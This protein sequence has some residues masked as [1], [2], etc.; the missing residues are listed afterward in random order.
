MFRAQ[1]PTP[2]RQ[3]AGTA[4]VWTYR[5]LKP[6][7]TAV[8]AADEWR[9]PHLDPPTDQEALASAREDLR[10]AYED[11]ISNVSTEEMAAS[12]ETSAFMDLWVRQRTPARVLDLGSGF[13]TAV[14]ARAA[15]ENARVDTVD[16]SPYWLSRTVAM[17]SGWDLNNV[18]PHLWTGRQALP[19]NGFD[20]VFHDLGN[21]QTRIQA[22]EEVTALVSPGGWLL[23]D[24]VHKLAYRWSAERL[25]TRAGFDIWSVWPET[26]DRFDRHA[27]LARRVSSG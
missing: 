5:A 7:R 11:Y 18:T 3:M 4:A 17:L 9:L 12:L 23:V 16:D 24:D 1:V 22:L 15:G 21:M 19:Q 20:F 14:L 6:V 13:S 8:R 27:W 26:H 2:I 25:L 10:S